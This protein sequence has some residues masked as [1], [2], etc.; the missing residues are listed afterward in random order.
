M[1][2]K[3]L[4]LLA[5]VLVPTALFAAE[6]DGRYVL[7]KDSRNVFILDT[8]TGKMWEMASEA[9]KQVMLPVLFWCGSDSDNNDIYSKIPTCESPIKKAK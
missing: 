7:D 1:G 4:L 3:R 8:R 9:D 5:L 6:G 2:M